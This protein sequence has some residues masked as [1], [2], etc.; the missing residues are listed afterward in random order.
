[1][2]NTQMGE[3]S[4]RLDVVRKLKFDL[5]ALAEFEGA[6]G[7][8]VNSLFLR[9][10]DANEAGGKEAGAAVIGFREVR[11]LVWA[12]LLHENPTLTI[13]EAG[14]LAEQGDGEEMTDKINI[15]TAKLMEA[16]VAFQGPA[17]KKNFEQA[18]AKLEAEMQ[19]ASSGTGSGSSE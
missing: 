1:M 9:V 11:A 16:Y 12:A 13:K 14:K 17:A 7:C 5:N 3:V 6:M 18:K 2:A 19:L 4:V 15:L 8:S 10:K